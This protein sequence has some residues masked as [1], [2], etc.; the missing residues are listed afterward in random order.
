MRIYCIDTNIFIYLWKYFPSDIFLGIWG[1]I[2]SLIQG[3]RLITP[4]EVYEE[5]EDAGIKAWLKPYRNQVVIRLDA[6][7]IQKAREIVNIGLIDYAKPRP[8]ADPFLVGLALAL[9]ERNS[10]LNNEYLVV[11]NEKKSNNMNNPKIPDVCDTY[12]IRCLGFFDLLREEGWQ[13]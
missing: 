3:G 5:I 1:D 6:I 4:S 13:Y 7:Q 2:L 10:L 8:D 11:S 9:R 12:G